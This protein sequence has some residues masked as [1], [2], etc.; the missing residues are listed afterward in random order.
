MCFDALSAFSVPRHMYSHM[1][2]A[3]VT[4]SCV[5]MIMRSSP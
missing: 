5:A 1:H 3:A 4:V 2:M